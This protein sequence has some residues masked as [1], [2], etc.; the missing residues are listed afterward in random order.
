MWDEQKSGYSVKLHANLDPRK[1]VDRLRWL[2]DGLKST[3]ECVTTH[4]PNQL[5]PKMDGIEA[6][7]L[8]NQPT[9]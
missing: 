3:N 4:L 6:C 7:D 5:A 2:D 9:R 1:G 8:Y